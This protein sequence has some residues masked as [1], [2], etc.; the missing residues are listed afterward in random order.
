M[1][2]K[3]KYK[4]ILKSKDS[5]TIFTNFTY[6]FLLQIASYV[7]PLITIPYLATT[8]GAEGYGKISF[9]AAIMAWIITITDWGFNY[10]ATRDVARNRDNKEVISGI[11]STVLWSRILLTCISF[12]LL[13]I[14]TFLIPKLRDNYSIILVSFLMIPGHICFPQWFFQA[15]EKMRFISILNVVAKLIFT[16][17]VFIFIK[18][19]EDYILQPLITSLGYIVS[20]V[21]SLYIIIV[22]WDI[23][24]HKFNIK[25]CIRTIKG[26]TDVFI[27]NLM[28]NL[29]NSLS[30]VLLGFFGGSVA[31]GIFDAANR[32][33]SIIQSF[34]NIISRCFFPFLAR[35]SDKF[36]LY[37][38]F[39][40]GL[41]LFVTIVLYIAAPFIINILYTEEFI[42]SINILRILSL[43]ILFA[44]LI[45]TYGVNYLLIHGY[46]RILRN[47]TTVSSVI[48]LIIGSFLI[49]KYNVIGTALTIVIT[50]GILGISI[51]IAAKKYNKI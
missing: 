26:S 37:E 21:I 3:D 12:I 23:K 14:I 51:M 16:L 15:I 17:S 34:F 20:G 18:E 41:S 2:L 7:F 33:E 9:A 50:R 45:N 19:K 24:V 35:R 49:Y 47:I 28:P 31:N 39:N 5:K 8:I 44:T 29:Y 4:R 25:E 11:F 13:L 27:N 40:L 1:S 10:T 46:E 30:V 36:T 6:L 38:R 43:S 22:K 32:I 48:G 42:E